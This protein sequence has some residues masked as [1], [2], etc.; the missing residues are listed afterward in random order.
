MSEKGYEK[1]CRNEYTDIR[2]ITLKRKNVGRNDRSIGE[3]M[4]QAKGKQIFFATDYFDVMSVEKKQLSDDFTEIMGVCQEERN[5]NDEISVQSFVLYSGSS[6]SLTENPFDVSEECKSM[7]PFLSIIQIHITPEIL[8]GLELPEGNLIDIFLNDLDE[9]LTD[10]YNRIE[11]KT[12]FIYGIYQLLSAGDFAVVIRSGQARTAFDVSTLIRKRSVEIEPENFRLVLYKTYTIFTI[13]GCIIDVSPAAEIARGQF[14]I[15]GCY[16][17]LYWSEKDVIE[18]KLKET[19]WNISDVYG[20]NGRYDFSVRMSVNEFR[21]LFPY[22]KRYKFPEKENEKLQKHIKSSDKIE[23]LCWLMENDYVSYLNERYLLDAEEIRDKGES[24]PSGIV[25]NRSENKPFLD[26]IIYKRYQ[27]LFQK[28]K[29][30]QQEIIEIKGYRKSLHYYIGLLGKLIS[31]CQT[32]NILSDTRIF[33]MVLLEQLDIILDSVNIYNQLLHEKEESNILDL[34]DEYLRV[35]VYTLD[36][37]A[38][39]IRNNNLQTVQTPNYNIETKVS[40][41]KILIGYSEFLNQFI[42]FYLNSRKQGDGEEFMNEYLPI[43]VPN[44]Q[45]KEVSVEVMFQ[46]GNGYDWEYEETIRKRA[47][48]RGRKYLLVITTPTLYDLN[49]TV[50]LSASLFHEIAHQ[51]RYESRKRR[52]DTLLKYIIKRVCAQ[53]VESVLM[54]CDKRMEYSSCTGLRERFRDS[55]KDNILKEFFGGEDALQYDFDQNPLNSFLAALKSTVWTILRENN[56]KAQIDKVFHRLIIK[57]NEYIDE[58]SAGAD[59]LAILNLSKDVWMEELLKGEQADKKILGELENQIVN[60]AFAAVY[61]YS[62]NCPEKN[63]GRDTVEN[64]IQEIHHW[65]TAAYDS[66]ID[67]Q[68]TAAFSLFADWIYSYDIDDICLGPDTGKNKAL[69]DT[70][71]DLCNC[72]NKRIRASSS[73][74]ELD[75]HFAW[76]EYGRYLGIDW[77]HEENRDTF[78][79]TVLENMEKIAKDVSKDIE[80]A[81]LYYREETADIFMNVVLNLSA[82]GYL[83]LLAE[84]LPNNGDVLKKYEERIIYVL[85]ILYCEENGEITAETLWSVCGE[86]MKKICSDLEMI[87]VRHKPDKEVGEKL[88]PLLQA[89][90]TCI[91]TSGSA[92][93]LDNL[94]SIISILSEWR[95]RDEYIGDILQSYLM[96]SKMLRMIYINGDDY[97]NSLNTYGELKEDFVIGKMSI[98]DFKNKMADSANKAQIQMIE[99]YCRS[100]KGMLEEP[101]IGRRK[102]KMSEFNADS[103][104]FFL[105]MYYVNKI[106]RAQGFEEEECENQYN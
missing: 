29:K 10:Y 42:S 97:I 80:R 20:L 46:E 27:N 31:L 98:K 63:V 26:E 48:N 23:Y 34:L 55:L 33:A 89:E 44:L 93:S 7:N 71:S 30:I 106:N 82:F 39:Y 12:D 4:I 61:Y 92:G 105:T 83:N 100:L 101:Y 59:A 38:N 45:A 78:V 65:D 75:L 87:L 104:E 1:F 49:C 17:N 9:I 74:E 95:T 58:S 25:I 32:I 69:S 52:N 47:G 37:Y 62:D 86:V 68:L 67:G 21:E 102:E 56:I 5:G 60:S 99:Q 90:K 81:V 43:V 35:S 79:N 3:N 53:I 94:D 41:E 70:Y 8:R 28:Y 6:R 2:L 88:Y 73:D 72:W 36:C 96:I 13:D 64:F 51:F 77:K 19:G 18:I 103:I 76:T 40:M 14:V 84:N 50:N 66:I 11:G 91:W 24:M 54:E 16:S 57:I 85:C 22:L 15:R